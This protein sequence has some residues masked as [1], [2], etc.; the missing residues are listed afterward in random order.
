MNSKI[1]IPGLFFL[2]LC[3][4]T[5]F[6]EEPVPGDAPPSEE[7][8]APKELFFYEYEESLLSDDLLFYEEF[9]LFG[10]LFPGDEQVIPDE[11]QL[12][13]ETSPDDES[14]LDDEFFLSDETPPSDE[15]L[16]S[17]EESPAPDETSLSDASLP[18]DDPLLYDEFF[19]SDGSLVFEA[20]PLIFEIPHFIF[21]TRSFDDIFP[22]F[23]RSKKRSV[24]SNEGLKY[25]FDKD[26]SAEL[27]PNPDSD[28]DLLSSVRA[29]NP[30]HLI[31]VLMVLPYGSERELD[32]LDIYNALGR[33]ENLKDHSF[34]INDR[35]YNI[36]EETTR[37][38]SARN[39]RSIPDPPPADTLPYAQTMYLRFKDASYGNLF[40]RGDISISLYG[41]TYSMTNFTDIRYFLVPIIR[42]ERIS[43][44][45][46]LEPIKEG[47]LIYSVSGLY[48]PGFISDRVNLT[49]FINRRIT[50]LVSWITEGIR[51]Q[52]SMAAAA[53]AE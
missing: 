1:A 12:A 22:G 11:S 20:P 32:L 3:M 51:R 18:S 14:L 29:R 28:I 2:F 13:D 52:E 4:G 39:R 43:I 48:L 33:I 30:S 40:I 36:F 45:I 5:I 15:S 41:I 42:A 34:I 27:I 23:S 19:P 53:A 37:L 49:P 31:E 50:A 26:G 17:E 25:S 21:E 44:I 35:S 6:S 8:P 10:E 24:F 38:E 7:A 47:V 9:C 16:L 46:Y